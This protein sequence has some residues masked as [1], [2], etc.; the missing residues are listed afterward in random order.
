[1]LEK[2]TTNEIIKHLDSIP[3]EIEFDKY[4]EEFDNKKWISANSIKKCEITVPIGKINEIKKKYY[5]VPVD[6]VDN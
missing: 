6:E 4:A 5:L 2:K 1:M 3:N